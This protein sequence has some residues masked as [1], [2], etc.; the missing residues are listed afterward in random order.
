MFSSPQR[1]PAMGSPLQPL[2]TKFLLCLQGTRMVSLS[3][4]T[5]ISFRIYTFFQLGVPSSCHTKFLATQ[6]PSHFY[7][8]MRCSLVNLWHCPPWFVSHSS[9]P[10][11]VFTLLEKVP[12]PEAPGGIQCHILH[13]ISFMCTVWQAMSTC[14][15]DKG[16]NLFPLFS[17]SVFHVHTKTEHSELCAILASGR[18]LF[19]NSYARKRNS[20]YPEIAGTSQWQHWTN[21]K[22]CLCFPWLE[23]WEQGGENRSLSCRWAFALAAAALLLRPV[24]SQNCWGELCTWRKKA[25]LIPSLPMSNILPLLT[26]LEE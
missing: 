15:L 8:Y 11:S 25:V 3:L 24:I 1:L 5:H 2:F 21:L 4:S 22:C 26:K 23:L 19:D 18:N 20:Q 7:F 6:R 12:F 14:L 9:I 10:V 16:T 13:I 17:F